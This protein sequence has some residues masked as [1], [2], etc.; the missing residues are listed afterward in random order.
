MHQFQ[1]YPIELLELN[2][3][4]K[5]SQEWMLITAGSAESER[6][7]CKLGRP[8]RS[9]GEKCCFHLCPGTSIYERIH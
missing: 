9:L 6:N 1:P 7:D 3:F 2:P 8:W 4:T 5:I